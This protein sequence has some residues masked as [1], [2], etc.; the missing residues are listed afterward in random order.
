MWFGPVEL[1]AAVGTVL[2]H[3]IAGA[4][5]VRVFRKGRVLS[6]DD[7]AALAALGRTDVYVARLDPDDVDENR[8]A[9]RI[10][11]ALV[12]AGLKPAGPASGRNNLLST[13]R[14]VLR[15]DVDRLM[16]LNLIDGLTVATLHSNLPVRPRQ[17]AAT[18]KIIPFALPEA[19]VKAAE[20]I[21]LEA[22][23]AL[24]VDAF[25]AARV[26][27]I[28]SGSLSIKDRLLDD[29]APLIER[30]EALGARVTRTDFV[31]VETLEGELI[32]ARLLERLKSEVVRA[33]LIV[34]AGETAIM[35]RSDSVPRAL[36]R[37]GGRVD[38][39]GAPVDPGNLLMLGDLDGI[40]VLGAPGCARSRKLNVIDWVLPRLLVGDHITRAEIAALGHGGLLEDAPER[41]LP[42]TRGEQ[43]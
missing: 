42:R 36:E 40:P 20:A 15:V 11:D 5:G 41:P 16:R 30:L 2:A 34:L 14:G 33:D 9:R 1:S 43:A 31:V 27:L 4:D 12:G 6:A 17:I 28:F 38:L 22:G 23:S 13:T 26:A 21:A 32:L 10:G 18:V 8:A 7:I 3:N 25:P 24:S 37:A 29:F 19:S 39:V 35:D